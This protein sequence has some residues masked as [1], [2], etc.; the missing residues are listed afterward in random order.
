MKEEG[1]KG[2]A[3]SLASATRLKGRL[4]PGGRG[5]RGSFRV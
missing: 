4:Q 3:G 2:G 5:T 1:S